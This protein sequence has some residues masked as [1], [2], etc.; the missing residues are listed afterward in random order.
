MRWLVALLALFLPPLVLVRRR[1]LWPVIA[2][3]L[4]VVAVAVFFL[5]AWGVG[6][7]LAAIAGLLA[8]AL[9]LR[10]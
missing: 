8:F 10:R 1:G 4:W 7:I 6:L 9:A 2:V 5:V 3:L